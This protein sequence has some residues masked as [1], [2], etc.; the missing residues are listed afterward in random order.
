MSWRAST[1][2]FGTVP[3]HA[4]A[5]IRNP[6]ALVVAAVLVVATVLAVAAGAGAA[7]WAQTAPV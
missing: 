5:A 7:A 6:L 3:A 1:V 4:A 2:P